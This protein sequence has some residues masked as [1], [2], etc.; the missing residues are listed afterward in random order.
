MGKSDNA[1]QN[2]TVT[3]AELAA[4]ARVDFA[5]F[6]EIAFPVLHPNEPLIWA[7]YIE[8]TAIVLQLCGTKYRR[9]V[10]NMPPGH[11]KSMLISVLYVAWRLGQDPTLKFICISYGDDLAHYLSSRVR[12]LML[13]PLYR[14]IF[15]RTVL[16]KKAEDMLQ[17]T[18]GGYRYSTSVGSDITGFRADYIIV[19]DPLQP[20]DAGSAAKKAAATD[21]LRES[22]LSRF[23]DPSK[24]VLITVMHRLAPDD[25]AGEFE[26]IADFVLKLPLIAEEDTKFRRCGK[27]IMHR[28][29]GDILHPGRMTI[30]DVE[31]IKL[32][33]P[34]HVFISQYQQRPVNA[35]S[36]MCSIDR[37]WRYKSPP[38]FELTIH[39]WDLAATPEG[40]YSVCTK[41]G[42]AK[43]PALGDVMFLIGVIRMRLEIPDVRSA[44]IVQDNVDKPDLIVLD[45][46]GI[47]VF[48]DLRK[49][50][51]RH[52]FPS[53][54]VSNL[55]QPKKL[56]RFGNALLYMYDGKV[57]FPERAPYL[58]DLFAEFSAFPTGKYDDQVDSTSQV[59]AEMGNC[60]MFARQRLR[61]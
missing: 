23:K 47:G 30:K 44:I 61:P 33:A 55:S 16:K 11:L 26:A 12:D 15:P 25:P 57:R 8:F 49:S 28:K 29:P 42:A 13:S 45:G 52:V 27:L 10:I 43:L 36:G 9:P 7:P 48:Q 39:S 46:L 60:L 5:T 59:I 17:T 22:V 20:A 38:P 18:K 24:G 58:D 40:N 3:A 31:R 34:P 50:G 53:N 14:R 35:G 32:E 4:V 6:I 51:Y 19:D 41:W 37:L 1:A 54:E 56:E 2:Q 21:W